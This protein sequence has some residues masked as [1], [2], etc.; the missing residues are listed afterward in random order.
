MTDKKDTIVF[1]A[2]IGTVNVIA[3]RRPNH[4]VLDGKLANVK[5]DASNISIVYDMLKI[6]F[7]TSSLC[8]FLEP[9]AKKY[10]FN[11]RVSSGVFSENEFIEDQ[12]PQLQ[13]F[14]GDKDVTMKFYKVTVGNSPIQLLNI[15]D[16]TSIYDYY[17]PMNVFKQ[18]LAKLKKIQGM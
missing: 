15:C 9:S 5:I 7:P 12:H 3:S 13:S 4:I 2:I 1:S 10:E 11:V 14:N 16:K 8:D 17:L 18:Q 6:E